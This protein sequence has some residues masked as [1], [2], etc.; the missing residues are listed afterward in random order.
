[1]LEEKE[2]K[3]IREHLEKTGN[4]LFFF[5]ND[6]DGLASFLLLARYYGKGKGVA[7]KSG[8]DLNSSYVRKVRELN[9][10]YVFILDKPLVSKE[11]IEE[12][13]KLNIPIVWIDHHDVNPGDI[14]GIYYYNSS[15]KKKGNEPVTYL[16]WKITGKKEDLWL[17]LCGCIADNYFPD[18]YEDFQKKW[19]ELWKP[20]IK[21]GFQ[22]L[23]ET[24]IGKITRILNFSLKDRTSNV[25]KMI[26]ILLKVSSPLEISEENS[27]FFRFSQ[28]DKK[29]S[30]LI[31]KA[32]EFAYEKLLYF[33]YSGDLSLSADIANEL[34]YRFPGKIVVV[35]YI[36]GSRANISIRGKSVRELTRKAISGFN[37]ATGGGHEDATGAKI[38]VSDLNEFRTRIERL[39][40]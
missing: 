24:G 9:P 12:V 32:R 27:G 21:T 35:V 16:A 39:V 29:Y 6:V 19:P 14:E 40:S 34:S 10:D 1:M 33:Q 30:K 37:N 7:I 20:G 13:K 5:D 11:F 38:D 36:S 18:F 4:P 31:E 22:V 2:I 3:E 25:I 23:Y 8:P 26:K 15:A 17:A 28:V